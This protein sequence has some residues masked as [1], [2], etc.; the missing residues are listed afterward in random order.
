MERDLNRRRVLGTVGAAVA[1]GAA[2]NALAAPAAAAEKTAEKKTKIIAVCCSPRKG[3][4]TAAALKVCLAAAA[5]I[6][7]VTTELIELAGLAIPGQVA[8]GI[9][10]AP[11]EKD[12]FP[13]LAPRLSDPSVGGIIIGT[14]VYFGNM[15]SLCKA[16]IDRFIVF[17]RGF[18]LADKVGGVVAVGGSR[19]GGQ[20]MTIRSVQTS[21]FAQEMILVGDGRPTAHCG[22]TVWSGG[23][24]SVTEDEFGMS[25]TKNLGKRV[26][27]LALRMA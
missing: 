2:T 25:T 5:E 11:G 19:N 6:P 18:A 8:A 15:T 7:G 10:L 12:D 20:E 22:A 24:K 21:L 13:A 27:K 14:P 9:K 26:A 3:K 17:R 4:S 16:F 1:V 23:K